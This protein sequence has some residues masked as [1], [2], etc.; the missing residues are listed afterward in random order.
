MKFP[1]KY[2]ECW[3]HNNHRYNA[4]EYYKVQVYFKFFL[5]NM[6]IIML[7]IPL[8]HLRCCHCLHPSHIRACCLRRTSYLHA[9]YK[10]VIMLILFLNSRSNDVVIVCGT[11]APEGCGEWDNS[12]GSLVSESFL[13]YQFLLYTKCLGGKEDWNL[14]RWNWIWWPWDSKGRL[15]KEVLK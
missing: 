7:K 10:C 5:K 2:W 13:A 1:K 8:L 6:K 12:I 11:L 9:M 15:K 14:E 4:V 3:F